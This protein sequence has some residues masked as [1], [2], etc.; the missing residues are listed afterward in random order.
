[1]AAVAVAAWDKAQ[2]PAAVEQSAAAVA[3]FEEAALTSDAGAAALGLAALAALDATLAHWAA[4]PETGAALAA[5]LAAAGTMALAEAQAEADVLGEARSA[6]ARARKAA[7]V[8]EQQVAAWAKKRPNMDALDAA[9]DESHDA[10]I[11]AQ[12]LRVKAKRKADRI[13]GADPEALAHAQ[14]ALDAAQLKLQQGQRAVEAE[15]AALVMLAAGPFPELQADAMLQDPALGPLEVDRSL[16]MYSILPWPEGSKPMSASLHGVSFYSFDGDLV[17]LKQVHFSRRFSSFFVLLAIL[18][19]V[20]ADAA[21]VDLKVDRGNDSAVRAL[22][23]ELAALRQLEGL[24]NVATVELFFLDGKF[25]YLQTRFFPRGTL[26]HYFKDPNIAPPRMVAPHNGVVDRSS[27]MRAAL[28]AARAA[29]TALR[30]SG[31]AQQGHCA[32]RF[33]ARQRAC[34]HRRHRRA[35]GL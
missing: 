10:V 15:R 34:S 6:V 26:A 30:L 29:A 35:L 8:L 7:A 28:Y 21:L 22:K 19:F 12:G 5:F 20:V 32:R 3:E 17:V 13:A 2:R 16:D 24:P 14:A 11:D 1:M 25:A 4:E 23:R 27:D 9:V 33:E 31:G 18:V